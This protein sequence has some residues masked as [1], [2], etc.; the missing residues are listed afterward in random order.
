MKRKYTHANRRSRSVP[1]REQLAHTPKLRST[2]GTTDWGNDLDHTGGPPPARRRLGQGPI[3]TASAKKGCGER[4]PDYPKKPVASGLF[5]LL[6]TISS[7]CPP[8]NA[9]CPPVLGLYPA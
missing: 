5:V 9:P 8:K 7:G 4:P 1:D 2:C 3:S 6:T